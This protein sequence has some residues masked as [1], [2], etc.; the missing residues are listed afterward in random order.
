MTREDVHTYLP[1]LYGF[2]RNCSDSHPFWK[3]VLGVTVDDIKSGKTLLPVFDRISSSLDAI[4]GFHIVQQQLEAATSHDEFMT[5]LTQVYVAYL[6]RDHGPRF[7]HGDHGFHIEVDIADQLLALGV[8]SLHDFSSPVIQFAD[9]IHDTVAYL[10]QLKK[11]ATRFA[12]HPT[13][14]HSVL[15]SVS[16]HSQLHR[17]V[18]FQKAVRKQR[19]DMHKHFPHVSGIVLIDPTPGK[20]HAK[21]VPFHGDHH[22]LEQ[23]LDKP[24]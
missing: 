23:L 21:F 18:E 6:Y 1:D 17:V 10:E 22:D 14:H 13:A 2:F 11:E 24:Q 19:T 15:A 7:I 8:V 20:E 9:Q 16:D 12:Q 5:L 4:D 3:A